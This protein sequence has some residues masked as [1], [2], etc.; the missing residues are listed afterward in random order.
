MSAKLSKALGKRVTLISEK[1]AKGQKN[2]KYQISEKLDSL[3][4]RVREEY[5]LGDEWDFSIDTTRLLD[6]IEREANNR[7]KGSEVFGS[8]LQDEINAKIVEIFDAV[9]DMYS[10][11]TGQKFSLDIKHQEQKTTD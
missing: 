1:N 2:Y 10:D 11:K 5:N 8:T 6:F 4:D 7:K 3:W 9:S